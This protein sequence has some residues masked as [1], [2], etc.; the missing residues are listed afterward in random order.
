MLW[1]GETVAVESEATGAQTIRWVETWKCKLSLPV[2]YLRFSSDGVMFASCGKVSIA[3][4][5]LEA[6]LAYRHGLETPLAYNMGL[7]H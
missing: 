5:G 3:E 7:G 1:S 4:S 2:M 6:L